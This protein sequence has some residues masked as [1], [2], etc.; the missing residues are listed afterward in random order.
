MKN[1]MA[2]PK[3]NGTHLVRRCV[4]TSALAGALLLGATAFAAGPPSADQATRMYNRIAGVPPTAA[5]LA[6]MI[7]KIGRAHV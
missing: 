2:K 3:M 1:G 7:A 5:V 4:R 6:N